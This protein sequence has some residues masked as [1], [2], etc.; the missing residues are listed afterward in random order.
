MDLL[1]NYLTHILPPPASSNFQNFPNISLC[2]KYNFMTGI[3]LLVIAIIAY[4]PCQASF[5]PICNQFW[6]DSLGEKTSQQEPY[7]IQL[8]PKSEGVDVFLFQIK[9]NAIFE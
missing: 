5:L 9:C 6:P 2:A 3:G 7:P 8:N 1:D 4:P